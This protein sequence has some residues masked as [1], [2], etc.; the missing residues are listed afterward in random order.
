[1][2]RLKTL[3]GRNIF[4]FIFQD[5]YYCVII[6]LLLACFSSSFRVGAKVATVRAQAVAALRP[7]QFGLEGDDDD[8]EALKDDQVRRELIRVM[9]SDSSPDVRQAA[10]TAVTKTTGMLDQV[11]VLLLQRYVGCHSNIHCSCIDLYWYCMDGM[12]KLHQFLYFSW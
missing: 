1:M 7:F 8:E 2:C 12:V 11:L 6:L 9:T 3:C 5:N 10:Q 4:I